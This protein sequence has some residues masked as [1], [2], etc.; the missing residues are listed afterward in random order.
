[1]ENRA[2][3]SLI[4]LNVIVFMLVFSM[5]QEMLESTISGLSFSSE[6][7]FELWRIPSSIFLHANASHLF[8][9]ML[10][11]Y[12]FGRV[13]EEEVKAKRFLSIY[14]ISGIAGSLLYGL[15]SPIPAVGASGC[16]FGVMGAAMFLKPGRMINLYVFPLP[17]GIIAILYALSQVALSTAS[18]AETGVAYM[19]HVGGLVT[20]TVMMF[21]YEPKNAAK[22]LFV[23]L[24]F[25]ALLLILGPVFSILIG[26][27]Q[28]VLGVIDF[29]AGIF[30]YGG[31][32][33]LFSWLW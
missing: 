8:F 3:M 21:Y 7:I 29:V 2:T 33:L 13:L 9:N 12:F 18:I 27:G 5:P 24:G 28:A 22:G 23:I 16:I 26:I 32:K 31:A 20:G 25:L 30:L 1:M 11:L 17:L 4:L 6:K 19:A 10:A 15:T 14:F